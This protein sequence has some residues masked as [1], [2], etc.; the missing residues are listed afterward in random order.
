MRIQQQQMLVCQLV[1]LLQQLLM[2]LLWCVYGCG[3]RLGFTDFVQA[4]AYD[5]PRRRGIVDAVVIAIAIVAPTFAAAMLWN[6]RGHHNA[7][8]HG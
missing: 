2:L 1:L 8:P 4:V 7:M 3:E 5:L 6:A